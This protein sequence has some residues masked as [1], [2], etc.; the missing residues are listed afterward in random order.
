MISKHDFNFYPEIEN[1]DFY[2]K[3]FMK[4]EFHKIL[5]NKNNNIK[6]GDFKLLP[7]Q[8]FLNLHR[9]L[10]HENY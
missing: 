9:F 2:K 1:I 5:D 10:V 8:E 7:Q 3:I 4:K 6:N